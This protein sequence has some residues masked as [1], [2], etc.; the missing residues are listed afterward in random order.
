M[1]PLE[2]A[3]KYMHCVFKT[4]DFD[5][6]KTILSDDLQFSGPFFKF[7]SADQYVNSLRNDSPE[8]FEY[9]IIKSYTDNSSACLVYKFSKP[10]ISTCMAQTFETMDGKISRIQLIFDTGAFRSD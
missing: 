9:D 8:D 3:E 7:N 4:G 6:L 1:T 10:G 2:L 5:E